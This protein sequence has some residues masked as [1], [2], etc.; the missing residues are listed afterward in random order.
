MRRGLRRTYAWGDLRVA[1]VTLL[2]ATTLAPSY[3]GAQRPHWI[4]FKGDLG[5]EI[6]RG[7]AARL[8]Q[9][10]IRGE[11][12]ILGTP[13]WSYPV[14]VGFGFSWVSF[15][16]EPDYPQEQWNYVG[17]HLIIGITLR[18]WIALPLYVEGRV[19][20]RKIRPIWERNWEIDA[21]NY[22]KNRPYGQE[23]GFA[24][25][26]VL[27]LDLRMGPSVF[28]DFS[29]RLSEFATE[30]IWLPS[31]EMNDEYL[32]DSWT[33]GLQLGLLWFP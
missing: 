9:G 1:A 28:M 31:A 23:G 3:A 12:S 30:G 17:P 29:F 24:G 10:N 8:F 22:N 11:F 26:G 4:A 5:A 6:P 16:V 32:G 2:L 18:D 27:G 13:A 14:H 20:H 25:E 15:P 33:F 19:L 21:D 7:D